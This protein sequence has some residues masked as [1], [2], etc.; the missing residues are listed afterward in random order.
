[1]KKP[2]LVKYT[3]QTKNKPSVSKR[4]SQQRFLQEN[5]TNH[6]TLSDETASVEK[7]PPKQTFF[8]VSED[9]ATDYMHLSKQQSSLSV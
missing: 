5:G 1:M 3:H 2:P 7:F 9:L 8:S 4:T 6:L